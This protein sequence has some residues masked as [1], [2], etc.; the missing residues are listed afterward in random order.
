[1][2]SKKKNLEFITDTFLHKNEEIVHAISGV[3][4]TKT[5]GNDRIKK[6][7]LV[8]TEERIIFCA[9]RLSGYDSEIFHYNKISTFELSKKLM[10]NIVTFYSSGNKVSIKWINDDE[11]D[12]FIEYVNKKIYGKDTGSQNERT[13]EHDTSN[14]ENELEALKKIKMLKELLDMDAITEDEFESQKKQL[15]NL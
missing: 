12:D 8:A 13:T 3:Y 10:G 9:K 6:G 14:E 11:L 15:L 4:E 5:L 1:M 7:V 2:A